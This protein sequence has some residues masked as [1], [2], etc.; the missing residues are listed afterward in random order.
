ME[1]VY[2]VWDSC[3]LEYDN[4][5]VS[6]TSHDGTK[7]FNLLLTNIHDEYLDIPS[8]VRMS[9]SNERF[10][11]EVHHIS[12]IKVRVTKHNNMEELKI[13]FTNDNDKS[14]GSI[15]FN[16]VTGQVNSEWFYANGCEVNKGGYKFYGKQ[17]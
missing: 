13:S 5:N 3:L 7:R 14:T 16:N 6:M 1:S 8:K 15:M 2:D 10:F 12:K 9:V 17:L 11:E 4:T